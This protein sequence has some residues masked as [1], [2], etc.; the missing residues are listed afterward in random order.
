MV[1]KKK[2]KKKLGPNY[3]TTFFLVLWGFQ[4]VIKLV[5]T[6]Y[7]LPNFFADQINI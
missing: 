7:P 6:H 3:H 5:N 2:K 4:N 1:F